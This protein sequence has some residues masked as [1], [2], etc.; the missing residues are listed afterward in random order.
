MIARQCNAESHTSYLPSQ[1]PQPNISDIEPTTRVPAN[2]LQ[3]VHHLPDT[4]LALRLILDGLEEPRAHKADPAL[5]AS[6]VR[7]GGPV[8]ALDALDLPTGTTTTTGTG[9]ALP[10]HVR[11][12]GLVGEEPGVALARAVEADPARHRHQQ[13]GAHLGHVAEPAHLEGERAAGGQGTPDPA[14]ELGLA[15]RGRAQDPVQRRVREGLGEG[16]ALEVRRLGEVEGVA[17]FVA[18]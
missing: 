18:C 8:L 1:H 7:R 9:T 13:R 5:D 17:D 6:L 12:P 4:L 2:D 11:D 15:R 3:D 14:E 10:Q 16:A